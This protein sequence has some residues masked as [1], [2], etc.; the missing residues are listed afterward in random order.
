MP[1]NNDI[2]E[3][4]I[5]DNVVPVRMLVPED[6]GAPGPLLITGT[7]W[8][9]WADANPG[10]VFSDFVG[11]INAHNARIKASFPQVSAEELQ[12]RR[13]RRE[14]RRM[15][16]IEDAPINS[17]KSEPITISSDSDSD[18]VDVE[19]LRSQ[20]ATTKGRAAIVADLARRQ[21]KLIEMEA[22]LARSSARLCDL[23]AQHANLEEGSSSPEF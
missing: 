4:Q 13:L 16:D 2:S 22:A 10:G 5:I 11:H 8:R 3:D 20:A 12:A 7:Q 15:G 21:A 18:P 23:E 9:R 6:S 19:A 17:A 1:A 14:R